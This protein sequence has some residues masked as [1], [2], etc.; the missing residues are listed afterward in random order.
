MIGPENCSRKADS[1]GLSDQFSRTGFRPE[2]YRRQHHKSGV[3]YAR[4][5]VT[6]AGEVIISGTSYEEHA[7]SC[8]QRIWK[9][10]PANAKVNVVTVSDCTL[11]ADAQALARRVYDYYQR[12]IRIADKSS[13]TP[14][15][16]ATGWQCR[17]QT[18]KRCFGTA[19]QIDID[20]TGGFIAKVKT[21]GTGQS[22]L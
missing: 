7:E 9:S 6:S 19:E 1:Q 15:R 5:H 14:S 11:D 12:R 8:G 16:P 10:L 18:A 21:H 4:I 20:L 22:D 17:L 13:L 3:N 2:H